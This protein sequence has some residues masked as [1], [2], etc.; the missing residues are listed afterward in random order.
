MGKKKTP[1][2]DK[3]NSS[4]FHLLHRSQR[5]A[6]NN[7]AGSGVV[8]WPNP[9]NNQATNDK[10]LATQS[11]HTT[12]GKWKDEMREVGLVDD[13]DYEKHMMPITGSGDFFANDGHRADALRDPRAI[14]KE[15]DTAAI[16]EISRQLDSIAVTADCMDPDVAQALFGE[17]DDGDFEEI[18]DDFCLTAAQEPDDAVAAEEVFDFDEHVRQLMEKARLQRDEKGIETEEHDWGRHDQEFFNKGKALHRHAEE[19]DDSGNYDYDLD[20]E[21]APPGVVSALNADEEKALCDKFAQTLLEYD[22]DEVGDLDEEC[23]YI[24]GERELEG[25]KHVEAAL[26]QYLEERDD[27]MFMENPDYAKGSGF[28]TLKVPGSEEPEKTAEV[29]AEATDFLKSPELDLPPEEILIDGQS[30]FSLSSRNPWDCESVLSTYSNLDNNPVTIDGGRRRGKKKKK[31]IVAEPVLEEEEEDEHAEIKL[32]NKTGLPLGVLTTKQKG[33]DFDF[34]T[35]ASVNK[36]E[37]RNKTESVAQKKMRKQQIKQERQVARIQKKMMK[38]AFRDEFGKA[39]AN[40]D[41]DIAGKTV[42]RF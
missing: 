42:F 20:D 35:I 34:D 8:L 16:N 3:N 36:G 18:L 39:D 30:Y 10:V 21:D 23:R 17:F 28:F 12:L 1:F 38:E 14:E 25:N 2:I 37:K 15:D 7:E 19:D 27:G 13:Y 5:D 41:D 4:T 11:E 40:A 32:S 24:G 6:E 29:L 9:E 31:Q 33:D 26:D 22:S